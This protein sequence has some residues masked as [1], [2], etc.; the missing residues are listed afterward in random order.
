M[1]HARS[2]A[3][4][5]RVLF[6]SDRSTT[7]SGVS[8]GIIKTMTN[9]VTGACGASGGTATEPKDPNWP[10]GIPDELGTLAKIHGKTTQLEP[11][12]VM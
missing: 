1:D 11:G 12:V 4:F 6:W 9:P 2:G 7:L 10:P 5:S 8:S 3:P